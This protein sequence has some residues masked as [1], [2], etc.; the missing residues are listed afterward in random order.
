M[1]EVVTNLAQLGGYQKCEDYSKRQNIVLFG[2]KNIQIGG[3][4]CLADQAGRLRIA[5]TKSCLDNVRLHEGDIWSNGLTRIEVLK[6]GKISLKV[7]AT[8]ISHNMEI[9]TY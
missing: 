7:K 2:K 1:K 9:Q 5:S 8:T 6:V 4:N 3:I